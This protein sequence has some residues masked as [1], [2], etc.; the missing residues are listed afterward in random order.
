MEEAKTLPLVDLVKMK[1][2][3]FRR[4]DQVH[5]LDMISIGIIDDTW[6]PIFCHELQVRLQELLDDPDG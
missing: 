3:S 4:K 2:T 1:L 6:L 5:I